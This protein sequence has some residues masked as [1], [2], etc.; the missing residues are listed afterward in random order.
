MRLYFLLITANAD[1]APEAADDDDT[2]LTF[3]RSGA[4]KP[5][6]GTESIQARQAGSEEYEQPLTPPGGAARNSATAGLFKHPPPPPAI[7]GSHTD[8]L[9]CIYV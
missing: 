4:Q 7:L 1:P 6:T 8:Y 9:I 2:E 5:A 3:L